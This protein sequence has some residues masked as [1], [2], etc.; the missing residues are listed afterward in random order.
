MR[1]SRDRPRAFPAF[2]AMVTLAFAALG[3]SACC[4]MGENAAATAK[5]SSQRSQ[6]GCAICCPNAGARASTWWGSCSCQG[7]SSAGP[8]K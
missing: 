6:K 5:C 1:P 7:V 3:V 2:F 4:L 8:S